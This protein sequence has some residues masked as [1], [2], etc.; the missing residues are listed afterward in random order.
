MGFIR[1]LYEINYS[2]EIRYRVREKR[3]NVIEVLLDSLIHSMM[4]GD[5]RNR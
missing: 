1:Y 5:T 2:R 3:N 4:C